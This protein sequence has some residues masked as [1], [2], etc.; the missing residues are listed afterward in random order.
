[1]ENT[2]TIL[3]REHSNMLLCLESLSQCSSQNIFRKNDL[4]HLIK[5][6]SREWDVKDKCGGVGSVWE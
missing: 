1:M 6:K 5:G 2:A 4:V 3:D